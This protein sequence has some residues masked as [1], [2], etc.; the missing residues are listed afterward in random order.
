MPVLAAC[1]PLLPRGTVPLLLLLFLPQLPLL[2]CA[3]LFTRALR[4]PSAPL[5]VSPALPPCALTS[6]HAIAPLLTSHP[7]DSDGPVCTITS[8]VS[9]VAVLSPFCGTRLFYPCPSLLP[10]PFSLVSCRTLT[11]PNLLCFCRLSLCLAFVPPL[12]PLP[13]H[14]GFMA[15]DGGLLPDWIVALLVDGLDDGLLGSDD[16]DFPHAAGTSEPPM[17]STVANASLVGPALRAGNVGAPCHLWP[18]AT[19]TSPR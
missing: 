5:C 10:L 7:L 1:I 19:V 11:L 12:S 9:A 16:P 15:R 14:H 6:C 13:G 3:S 17:G 18:F 8:A 4:V 2:S